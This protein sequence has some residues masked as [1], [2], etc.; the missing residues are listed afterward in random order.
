ME[1]AMQKTTSFITNREALTVLCYKARTKRLEHEKLLYLFY[2]KK[3]R[4]ILQA[5]LSISKTNVISKANNSVV[6]VLYTLIKHATI[7]QSE[8]LL[9]W[10]K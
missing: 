9:K 4:Y 7:S 6:S 10:F 1:I 3:I 5:L 2:N 8:S